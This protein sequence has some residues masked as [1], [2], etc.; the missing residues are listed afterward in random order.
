MPFNNPASPLYSS[1]FD[2]LTTN[3]IV[4]SDAMAY[5]CDF[6]NC[7][8]GISCETSGNNVNCVSLGTTCYTE[9]CSVE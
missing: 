1:T 5:A 8:A 7:F 3:L 2:N 6:T 4:T 9:M